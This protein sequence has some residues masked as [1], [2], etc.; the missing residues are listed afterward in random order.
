MKSLQ[1]VSRVSGDGILRLQISTDMPN[2]ELEEVIV[3]QPV[4]HKAGNMPEDGE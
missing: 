2:Q 4:A 3:L 1:I